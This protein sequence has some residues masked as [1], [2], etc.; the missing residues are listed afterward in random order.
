MGNQRNGEELKWCI[1]HTNF[2]WR[3]LE[4]FQLPNLPETLFELPVLPETLFE[5]LTLPSTP[6]EPPGFVVQ[7]GTTFFYCPW[8]ETTKIC[9]PRPETTKKCCLW[10]ATTNS[11]FP[12]PGMTKFVVKATF[13]CRPNKGPLFF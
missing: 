13:F 11:C 1:F 7:N 12:W 2:K 9:R 3:R 6:F 5:L 10:P 8:P 4:V